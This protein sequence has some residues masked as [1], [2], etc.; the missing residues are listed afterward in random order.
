MECIKIDSLVLI[1]VLLFIFGSIVFIFYRKNKNDSNENLIDKTNIFS[2]KKSNISRNSTYKKSDNFLEE[3]ASR[4][5]T[6]D[7]FLRELTYKMESTKKSDEQK[8]LTEPIKFTVTVKKLREGE[9]PYFDFTH[10]PNIGIYNSEMTQKN[11]E[12]L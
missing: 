7:D 9:Y 10:S 12:S 2:E 11:R 1:F 8:S 6:S 4:N 5:I 3:L